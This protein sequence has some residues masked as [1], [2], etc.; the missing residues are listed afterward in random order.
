M[1]WT[2]LAGMGAFLLTGT[3][4][5]RKTYGPLMLAMAD[6]SF[7][8]GLRDK[9]TL[10]ARSV[11]LPTLVVFILTLVIHK[12]WKKTDRTLVTRVMWAVLAVSVCV[13]AAGLEVPD[14][15]ARQYRLDREQW[16][17]IDDRVM[18]ALGG[19]DDIHYTNSKEA[20]ENS[21][22]CGNRLFECDMSMTADGK[23]AAC[24]DWVFWNEKTEI[25]KSS[26]EGQNEIYVPTL[27]VFM[28]RKFSGKYTPLSGADIV[29]FLKEHPDAYI[30]TDTKSVEPEEIRIW[31]Q[32]LVNV[33]RENGCE[34]TLDRFVVQIYR[35][36]MHGIVKE[37]YPF[38][39]Y[40]FTL[41]YE[42]Y[43]GEE[44]KMQEYAEFCMLNDIDV[45]TMEAKY[46]HDELLD[47]CN[48]YDIRLFVHT[49]NDRREI[50]AFHEKGIGVYT[51]ITER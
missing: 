14:F 28:D 10:F 5:I 38:P 34:E 47:I 13:V 49:V 11:M 36:Y 2:V 41:Y 46:Y 8:N 35:G 43:K 17:D 45:I 44:D 12:M 51:D 1:I 33:A 37:I 20:L 19:I 15:V 3:V 21:Y 7:R 29:L 18:H 27:D 22:A 6:E 23:L 4:W 39:H 50:E 42:A 31:V 30:I 9:R 32:E 25:E 24:H 26:G 40:I 48:R 16:F